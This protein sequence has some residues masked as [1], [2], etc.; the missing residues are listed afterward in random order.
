MVNSSMSLTLYIAVSSTEEVRRVEQT[1][2]T[3]PPKQ[4]PSRERRLGE[5]LDSPGSAPPGAFRGGMPVRM[6]YRP[7]YVEANLDVDLLWITSLHEV[8]LSWGWWRTLPA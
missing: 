3:T 1:W 6:R 4:D 7:G 8:C 2:P 5:A